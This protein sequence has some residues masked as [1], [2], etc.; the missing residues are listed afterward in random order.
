MLRFSFPLRSLTVAALFVCMAFAVLP[1]TTLGQKKTAPIESTPPPVRDDFKF[2]KV[3]LELL[4]QVDLLD[5]RFERDGMV[6]EDTA[7]SAYLTR[8]GETLIP[9]NLV[10]EKV[11]WKFR[12]LR[13]PQ[14]NSFALP[15]GSI[16][17][18]TGLL[19]L[20]DNESQLASVLAHE[21]THVMLRHQYLQNRSN[22]GKYLTMNVIAA[23]GAFSPGGIAG[24]VI[25]I[26]STV[27]PFIVMATMS[28]YS[29]DLEREADHR[30]IDMMITAEYPPEEEIGM[31]KLLSK[32][33]EGEQ[34]R[35]FYNDRPAIAERIKYLSS[36]LGTRADKITPQMELNRE[37]TRYFQQ[38]EPVMQHNVEL[39]INA[40]RFR[41]AVY[42]A[43]RL[44]EFHPASSRNAF[45]AA[46]AYRTL[47]PRNADLSSEVLS[48]DAKKDLAKKR[49]KQTLEEE[50]KALLTTPAGRQNWQTNQERSEAYYRKALSLDEPVPQAHRGLGM[51]YEK[52]GRPIE[53]LAEYEKYLEIV[54]S[55]FDRERIQKRIDALRST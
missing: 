33:I 34:I 1:P 30:A 12:A 43:E 54:P 37:K 10:L 5:R 21:M 23:V 46:E 48:N 22:R 35:L 14:P 13:D 9:H 8:I 39:A 24:A 50:E 41:S 32:D 2:D 25:S 17:V 26:A 45:L 18:T 27:A 44:V 40:S 52:L 3:D 19:S 29:R 6:F 4:G 15:N 49:I 53:A 47:G 11:S 38:M 20:L 16:Y 36:Y 31:L 55:A 42:F 51:L 7:T 28:G